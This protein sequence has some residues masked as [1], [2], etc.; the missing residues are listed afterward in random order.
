M[1][2][3]SKSASVLLAVLAASTIGGTI[4]SAEDV[5]TGD[6]KSLT[7]TG[8]VEVKDADDTGGPG[9]GGVTDPEKPGPTDPTDDKDVDKSKEKGPLKVE[10][11]SKLNFGEIQPT[12]GVIKE[13]AKALKTQKKDKD[14][15]PV[16]AIED[17]GAIVQFADVRA[18]VYGYELQVKMA[19][20]FT[21]TVEGQKRTLDSSTIT[22]NNG[23]MKA[24]DGNENNPASATVFNDIV[25]G[26]DGAAKTV[27][28][29]S[30]DKAK[31]EGKGRYVVEFGQSAD[32]T[33][34]PGTVGEGKPGTADSSVTLT[35]PTKTASNMKLGS[36]VAKVQWSLLTTP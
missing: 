31:E 20:Q 28:T 7:S 17:R 14:G 9:T 5:V 6:A 33:K 18:G 29:A 24:E 32:Y 11:I 34:Q 21:A 3:T 23:I 30:N 25:I 26:Q 13:N 35:V 27:V 2:F 22:Y 4:V 8:T 36:Y 1:K 16:G 12:A 10:A 15:K 19:E